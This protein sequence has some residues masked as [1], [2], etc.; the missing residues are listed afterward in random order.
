MRIELGDLIDPAFL[1][2]GWLENVYFAVASPE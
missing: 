1:E 2:G